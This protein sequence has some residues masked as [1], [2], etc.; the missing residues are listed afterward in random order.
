MAIGVVVGAVLIAAMQVP[1]L[2]RAGALPRPNLALRHPGG[3]ARRCAS[4]CRSS[5]AWSSAPSP[6]SSTATWPGGADED[7]LGAMRYATT[8]VQFVLGLVAAAISLAAL[9]TLAALP[10]RRR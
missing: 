3:A 7:A 5:S 9:P 4:T 8:L 6:S 10:H 1:P 2:R